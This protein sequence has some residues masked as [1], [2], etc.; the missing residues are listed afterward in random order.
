MGYDPI[1]SEHSDVLFD[2]RAH[3]H[4]SCVRQVSDADMMILLVGSRF[5]GTAIPDAISEVDLKS[6][7]DA[8]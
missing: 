5:G 2:P 8:T 4:T 6:V 1:M 7:S 3:T